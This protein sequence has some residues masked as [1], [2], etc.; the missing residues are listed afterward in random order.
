MG[1]FSPAYKNVVMFFSVTVPAKG[2]P[3]AD[4]I[5]K[6]NVFRK[7]FN[8]VRVKCAAPCAALLAGIVIPF[9]H[10]LSPISKFLSASRYF[11][12]MGAINWMIG[13]FSFRYFRAVFW[14]VFMF[15]RAGLTTKVPFSSLYLKLQHGLSTARARYLYLQTGITNSLSVCFFITLKAITTD[16]AGFTNAPIMGGASGCAWTTHLTRRF[17]EFTEVWGRLSAN[18]TG[19]KISLIAGWANTVIASVFFTKF[20]SIF[21]KSN[22]PEVAYEVK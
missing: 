3:V 8:V 16:K 1:K 10:F 22:L 20:T 4:V 19:R 18:D 5:P 12:L 17:P 21:H 15:C 6:L 13:N 11:V 14:R 7:G 9:K 2:D